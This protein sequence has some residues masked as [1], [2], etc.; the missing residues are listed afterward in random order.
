MI[1]FEDEGKAARFDKSL[2]KNLPENVVFGIDNNGASRNELIESLHLT[3]VSD[4][5]F[6]VADTFNRVVWVSTG[7]T[8]GMGE[9]LLSILSRLKD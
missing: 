7:Y 1:L 3:D 9:K 2:F 4:P 5:I 6:V 8:I